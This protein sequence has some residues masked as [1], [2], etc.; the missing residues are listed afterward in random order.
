MWEG[1]RVG[2]WMNGWMRR[3]GVALSHR[4]TER[5]SS[6]SPCHCSERVEAKRPSVPSATTEVSSEVILNKL[7]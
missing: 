3:K 4:L 7:I 6:S 1:R 2:E 5:Q